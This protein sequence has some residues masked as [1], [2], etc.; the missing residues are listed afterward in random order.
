[1]G[2]AGAIVHRNPRSVQWDY[3]RLVEEVEIAYGP[4]SE[5]AA[6]VAVELRQRVRKPGESLHLLR[7]DIYERVSVAY[8]DRT[9]K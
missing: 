9:E 3:G 6:A 5:H 2:A 1:M 7:D 4:S 8:S